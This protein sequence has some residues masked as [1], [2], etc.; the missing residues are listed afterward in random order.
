MM[1]KNEIYL[2]DLFE[3]NISA[4]IEHLK[5]ISFRAHEQRMLRVKAESYIQKWHEY[6]VKFN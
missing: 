4:K 6:K 2:K 5:N 3:N 1:L